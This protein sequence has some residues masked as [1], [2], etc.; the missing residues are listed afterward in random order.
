M[1]DCD[2]DRIVQVLVNLLGNAVKFSAVSTRIAIAVRTQPAS[3]EMTV[4]DQGP[5]IA[6]EAL[7]RIFDRYW[8]APRNAN[9]GTG[10]GLAI[11]QAFVGA[12]GG[13]IEVDSEP[14][15][16]T[17]FKLIFPSTA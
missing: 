4:R 15:R 17:A 1:L 12:H 14:A 7:P 2:G 11:V 6:A 8:H 13:Q 9:G 3:I 16:G 5:G 10:L